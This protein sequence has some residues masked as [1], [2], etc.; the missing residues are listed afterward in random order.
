[1]ER[2]REERVKEKAVS[3]L[4]RVLEEM[5]ESI[6]LKEMIEKNTVEAI[7]SYVEE[8]CVGNNIVQSGFFRAFDRKVRC[9]ECKRQLC[10]MVM[11]CGHGVCGNC[12]RKTIVEQTDGKI[13][14]TKYEEAAKCRVENCGEKISE[15][16]IQV[17][18]S[19]IAGELKEKAINREREQ[20]LERNAQI[21]CLKCKRT[22]QSDFYY[23]Q[24]LH[25]CIY[26]EAESLNLG[27]SQCIICN[28]DQLN[29]RVFRILEHSTCNVCLEK[30]S[31]IA[32]QLF[33]TCNEHYHCRKCLLKVWET[34]K[35]Q[36][37]SRNLLF[38]VCFI[39][40]YNTIYKECIKCRKVKYLEN[41]VEKACCM[42][43]LCLECLKRENNQGR[44]T[45][46]MNILPI[47]VA[48]KL[49]KSRNK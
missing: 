33:D 8:V 6:N 27:S 38:D 5:V 16:E 31:F 10:E 7:F 46:C 15:D 11:E 24:C 40:V 4:N 20:N 13:F 12:I 19:E 39:N 30:K 41:F 37:C 21:E 22:R 49:Q 48:L 1:M 14:T 36:V 47:D 35:C 43:Y 34:K 2:N 28:S 23:H 45:I 26:C 17:L 18:F 44:C 25:I 32:D 9:G 29:S 3:G 42:K